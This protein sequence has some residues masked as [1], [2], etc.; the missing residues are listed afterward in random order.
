M[1]WMTNAKKRVGAGN[2]SKKKEENELRRNAWTKLSKKQSQMDTTVHKPRETQTNRNLPPEPVPIP[3]ATVPMSMPMPMP[4]IMQRGPPTSGDIFM[5]TGGTV[6]EPLP[7]PHIPH[8]PSN[9]QMLSSSPTAARQ[10]QSHSDHGY[11]SDPLSNL[12][13]TPQKSKAISSSSPIDNGMSGSF[14]GTPD[15]NNHPGISYGQGSSHSPRGVNSVRTNV[16]T[17]EPPLVILFFNNGNACDEVTG[18]PL[19]GVPSVEPFSTLSTN[20]RI[21]NQLHS[22]NNHAT[23]GYTGWEAPHNPHHSHP[24]HPSQPSPGCPPPFPPSPKEVQAHLLQTGL[25]S[26]SQHNWWQRFLLLVVAHTS[27]AR[28]PTVTTF[29]SDELHIDLAHEIETVTAGRSTSNKHPAGFQGIRTCPLLCHI[30][31]SISYH[32]NVHEIPLLYA[33]N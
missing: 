28:S 10:F 15:R 7:R 5:L 25:S 20:R 26:I 33:R 13:F 2:Y 23:V 1:N 30:P 22:S 19:A 4:I 24:R 27:L 9:Q 17:D 11:S 8:Q 12:E 3:V 6:D 14:R 31:I 29:L 16:E 32:V 18:R 21:N